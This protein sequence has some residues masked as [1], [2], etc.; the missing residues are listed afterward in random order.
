[1]DGGREL[2]RRASGL[3]RVWAVV[4]AAVMVGVL[5]GCSALVPVPIPKQSAIIGTWRADGP[6]G[7]VALLKFAPG[8][9]LTGT[10][11]PENI[12]TS[13]AADVRPD[14]SSTVAFT[15]SW[16]IA[17]DRD[18]GLPYVNIDEVE[19]KGGPSAGWPL[20]VRKAAGQLQLFIYLGDP[21]SNNIFAFTKSSSGGS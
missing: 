15:G 10:R 2:V 20:H 11:F 13:T 14:W 3:R 7:Q 9:Q 8:G 17:K 21:D 18:G 19:K 12:I 6:D 1:M 16:V 5:A 4:V